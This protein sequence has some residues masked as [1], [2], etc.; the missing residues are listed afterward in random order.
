[1]ATQGSRSP[2]TQPETLASLRKI[3]EMLRYQLNALNSR[4]NQE[5]RA[6]SP[7]KA[8][9]RSYHTTDRLEVLHKRLELYE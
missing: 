1:M 6:S 4:L 8:P 9:A 5:L 3:H 7:S 2:A